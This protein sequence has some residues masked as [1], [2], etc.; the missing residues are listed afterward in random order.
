MK[1]FKILFVAVFLCGQLHA[2]TLMEGMV[3]DAKSKKPVPYVS[4]GILEEAKGTF[5]D[6][7][8]K[9]MLDL[10]SKDIIFS[11]SSIGF[12]SANIP[13]YDLKDS[14]VIELNPK[15]YELNVVEVTS[16][17]FGGEE[18]IIGVRNKTRGRS[19]AIGSPQ[20]GAEI[21]AVLGI[22]KTTFVKSSNRQILF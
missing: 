4:I 14:K 21:G 18:V 6:Q 1:I 20:L 3:I 12:E 22:K 11:V 16:Q 9:F 17:G 10:P 13:F 15:E 7:D 19:I 2:Q 5:S 8:G